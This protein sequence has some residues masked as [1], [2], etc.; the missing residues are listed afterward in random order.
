MNG[1]VL[2]SIIG[3]L[4]VVSFGVN[5]LISDGQG[6]EGA[7]VPANRKITVYKSPDCGCCGEWSRYMEDNGFEV[8]IVPTEDME[9]IRR[10]NGISGQM[11]SCH[12]AIVDGYFVEGH[13]PAEI[14][15]RMLEERPEIDGIALP[16]MPAGSP[17]MPGVKRGDWT[18]YS[19]DDGQSDEYV[20]L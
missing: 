3:A 9:S 19:I 2:A 1:K 12:T 4:V 15:E 17:G 13:V 11:R 14:V 10:A 8:D 18:I 7:A 20:T 5:A 6:A 16:E